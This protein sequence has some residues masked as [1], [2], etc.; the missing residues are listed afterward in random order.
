MT[1]E[2]SRTLDVRQIDGKHLS[3]SP[4]PAECAALA[5]RFGIVRIDEL[6]AELDLATMDRAGGFQAEARGRLT[7]RIVQPCAVSAED[8]AVT[9]DEPVFFRFVPRATDYAP[10]EEVELTADELDEVEYDG[11]H[12]DVGEAVAQSL[13]LAI[14]PFL[15]GPGADAARQAAGIGSPE[16]H[17]PFAALKGLGLGKG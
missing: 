6:V 5:E 17:G 1:P 16:D 15:T 3:L 9:I 10:D 12:I 13:A 14:D 2:F 8:L 11:T 7:G 4:T